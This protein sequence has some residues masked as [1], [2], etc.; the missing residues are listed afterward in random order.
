MSLQPNKKV[1]HPIHVLKD[2]IIWIWVFRNQAIV[3][4]PALSEPVENFLKNHA[5][6]L[7]AILQTHHHQDHIGGTPDLL[8][9]WPK[10]EVVASTND[11]KIPFKTIEVRDGETIS[12]LGENLQIIEVSGHTKHHIAFFLP[13]QNQS[14]PILFC[15]DTLF[16]GGCGRLFEGTSTDMF[17]SLKKLKELPITTKVY[18]A[19]EYT[20][21][22]LNWAN[23]ICPE[24]LL[25][26]KRLLETIRKRKL[27][28]STLP[29][30][31]L[32]EKKTNLF[33]RAKTIEEL[34]EL[35]RSKDS[36]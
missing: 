19:H 4:D 1:I 17:N 32:E 6:N 25:I 11:M 8:K 36:W 5:L 22:N 23:Y 13:S 34:S 14:A 29:S 27:G 31:I 12:L 16:G 2:N 10:A 28:L 30:T 18:C 26:K 7:K 21:S 20:E 9:L 15:G 24:D 3:V 33:L 35:R